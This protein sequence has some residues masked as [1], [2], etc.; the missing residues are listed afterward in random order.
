MRAKA[1]Q[2]VLKKMVPSFLFDF[3]TK[4]ERRTIVLKRNV[5]GAFFLRGIDTLLGF[6]RVPIIISFLSVSEYGIWLTLSSVIGWFAFFDVGLSNGLKTKLGIALGKKEYELAKTYVSTT[7]AT[8]AIIIGSVFLL[9]IMV[10]PFLNWSRILNV[11]DYLSSSAP[12]F[13]LV[14]SSLFAMQFI[15]NIISTVLT[16]DQKPTAASAISTLTSV[17]YLLLLVV[18]KI[19]TKGTLLSLTLICNGTSV[20]IYLAASVYLF[21]RKYQH[22]K[23]AFKSVDFSHFKELATLGVK[24]F[25]I[26][27]SSIILF[28][29]DNMIITQLYT[30]ADV[31]PYS[32]SMKYMTIPLMLFSMIT[33]PLWAAFSEAYAINDILWIKKTVKKLILLWF[34]MIIL[35]LGCLS[36]A[37]MFYRLWLRGEIIVPFILSAFM[38]I[39]SLL[40]GWNQI[41]VFFLNGVGK[42]KLQLYMSFITILINI[43]LSIYFAKGLNLGPAGVI[44]ATNV[45]IFIGSVWAPIQYKKIITGQAGGIWDA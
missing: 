35:V 7:Y 5:L 15:A 11:P 19:F 21:G 31:A 12:V 27:I 10:F 3:F 41:F 37:E 26:Q 18:L 36:F 33:W 32:V 9:F 30:P 8:I 39:Y 38:G 4:G 25:F 43:P 17:I 40:V 23:P 20:I 24:F 14:F 29:T 28:S 45:C 2:P 6:I 1:I 22:I 16:A 34:G 13:V 42:I 44:L